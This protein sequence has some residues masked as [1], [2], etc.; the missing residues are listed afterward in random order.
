MFSPD[1]KSFQLRNEGLP[2]NTIKEFDGNKKTFIRE[3]RPLKDL[4]VLASDENV[5]VTLTKNEVFIS[6]NAGFSW[7]TLGFS[8]RT[9]GG[10]AVAA[11]MLE[12]KTSEGTKKELTVF[13]SHALYGLSYIQ[14]DRLSS[15]WTDITDGIEKVPTLPYTDEIADI[16]VM[17]VTDTDGSL[18]KK[19]I[20]RKL[21]CRAYTVWIGKTRRELLSLGEAKPPIHGTDWES[22]ANTSFL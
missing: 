20:L 21:S 10:K 17:Q 1:L 11:A 3:V 14:P 2:V 8:S 4:E 12:E 5:L 18:K 19:Y 22:P 9:S 15:K 13:L 16:S 6:K 7:Q